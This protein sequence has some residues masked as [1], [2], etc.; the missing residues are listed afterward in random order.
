RGAVDRTPRRLRPLRAAELVA[1]ARRGHRRGHR[2]RCA[3]PALGACAIRPRAPDRRSRGMTRAPRGLLFV[4]LAG[5]LA[6][7]EVGSAT[8]TALL[9]AGASETLDVTLKIKGNTPAGTY[10]GTITVTDIVSG[11]TATFPISVTH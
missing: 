6:G 11:A 1:R 3:A 8:A 2:A 7:G 10:S 4:L 9:A 5:A